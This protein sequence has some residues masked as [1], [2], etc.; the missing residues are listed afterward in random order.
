MFPTPVPSTDYL[1]CWL[2]LGSTKASPAPPTG[3]ATGDWT[4]LYSSNKETATATVSVDIFDTKVRHLAVVMFEDGDI[5]GNPE[6]VKLV[7]IEG[8][9]LPSEPTCP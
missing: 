9:G 2:L 4:K 5:Q 7:E 6:Y 3:S 1:S 8:W